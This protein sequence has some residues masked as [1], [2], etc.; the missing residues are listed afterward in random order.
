MAYNK[1]RSKKSAA[2]PKPRPDVGKAQR[3]K[4]MSPLLVN[5]AL[6]SFALLGLAMA[7]GL[8]G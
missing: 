1:R 6:A 8:P 7:T 4:T 5:T 3:P 2:L